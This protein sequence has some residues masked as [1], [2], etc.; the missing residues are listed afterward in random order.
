[1][2]PVCQ[3]LVVKAYLCA[4]VTRATFRSLI[5]PMLASDPRPVLIHS[6]QLWL[7]ELAKMQTAKLVE[8]SRLSP[9]HLLLKESSGSSSFSPSSDCT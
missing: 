9:S 1:M 4:A 7:A 8:S 6:G 5:A 2:S 3:S